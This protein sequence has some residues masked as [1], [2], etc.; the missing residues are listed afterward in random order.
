MKGISEIT[1][2]STVLQIKLF[3][4]LS[5]SQDVKLLGSRRRGDCSTGLEIIQNAHPTLT[6]PAMNCPNPGGNV[7]DAIKKVMNPGYM[8]KLKR[9]K[10]LLKHNLIF[11]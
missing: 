9:K 2:H 1:S 10:S 3:S 4:N 8:R 6:S 7:T 5:S 11:L